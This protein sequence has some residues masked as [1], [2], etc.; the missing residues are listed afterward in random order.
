VL[1][2]RQQALTVPS[3]VVQR[4]QDGLFAYVV[5]A[6][7]KARVQPITVADALGNTTVVTQGLAAGDRVV[8]DGQYR[9]TPGARVAEVHADSGKSG[10]GKG[11]GGGSAGAGG[12]Q[13]PPS[14]A[15]ASAQEQAP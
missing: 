14:S 12:T 3:A 15:P 1:G 6:D 13:S 8:V 7:D 9:L 2:E 4:G 10:G 5:D 11:K